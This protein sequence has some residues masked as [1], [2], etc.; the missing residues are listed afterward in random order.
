VS[1]CTGK[2]HRELL[3]MEAGIQEQLEAG[4]AADPE[5]LAAVLRRLQLAKAK[6]RLREIQNRLLERHLARLRAAP[7]TAVDV[8]AAMG[9]DREDQVWPNQA[10]FRLPFQTVTEGPLG[11]HACTAL[12]QRAIFL[13]C[14]PA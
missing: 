4:D 6:A 7:D 14:M 13:A 9:W 2:S 1:I 12:S 10:S 5:F 8:A 11:M 3:E